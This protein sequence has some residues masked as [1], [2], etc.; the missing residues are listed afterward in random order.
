MA[1][2]CHHPELDDHRVKDT[3]VGYDPAVLDKNNDDQLSG[4]GLYLI[5]GL[6]QSVEIVPPGNL[7]RVVIS[8]F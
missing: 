3:G 5:R 7:I 6:A 8:S 1:K 4:R 2:R